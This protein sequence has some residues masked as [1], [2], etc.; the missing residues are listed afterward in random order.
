M[1]VLSSVCQVAL[2]LYCQLR[3][4]VY[5]QLEA[6]LEYVLLPLA[7]G[8][9]ASTIEQQETALEV[10]SEP[11]PH[12]HLSGIEMLN[13]CNVACCMYLQMQMPEQVIVAHV[14]NARTSIQA[15]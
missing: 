2:S 15:F 13:R 11:Q 10:S 1:A 9:T 4:H 7:E 14:K 3:T 6:F 8:K 5:L 12:E